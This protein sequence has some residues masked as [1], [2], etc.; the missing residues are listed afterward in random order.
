M[1]R[2]F[3]SYRGREHGGSA[4]GCGCGGGGFFPRLYISRQEEREWL[5]NYRDELKKEL[6]GAEERLKELKKQDKS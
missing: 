4:C 6:A 3:G 2:P 5:E 1:G